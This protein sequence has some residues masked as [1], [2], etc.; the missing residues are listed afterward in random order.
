MEIDDQ[1]LHEIVHS[2][3]TQLYTCTQ[4]YIFSITHLKLCSFQFFKWAMSKRIAPGVPCLWY[5]S[6][7]IN[8]VC[9]E[10]Y[11]VYSKLRELANPLWFKVKGNKKGFP[12]LTLYEI[13][14][15]WKLQVARKKACKQS[16]KPIELIELKFRPFEWRLQ[17]QQLADTSYILMI[18]ILNV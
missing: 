7:V 11:Q 6:F 10:K 1:L 13:G 2:L 3:Y 16:Q 15:I 17:H 9:M 8:V 12:C 5:T 18:V 4:G 14:N